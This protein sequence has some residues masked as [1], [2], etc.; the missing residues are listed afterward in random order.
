LAQE[1]VLALALALEQVL[2]LALEGCMELRQI[3]DLYL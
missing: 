1:Q 3:L 2:A